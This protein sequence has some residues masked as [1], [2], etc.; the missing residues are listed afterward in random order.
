MAGLINFH[1]LGPHF[2]LSTIA[3]SYLHAC[4]TNRGLR[5]ASGQTTDPCRGR[6]ADLL[7]RKPV[8]PL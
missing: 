6:Y 1:P 2:L 8:P 4:F 7:G 5:A 3:T